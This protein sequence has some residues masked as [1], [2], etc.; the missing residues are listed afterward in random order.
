MSVALGLCLL[1]LCVLFS[2]AY[3]GAE[4]G[5]YS[6]SR[7]QVDIEAR[8]GRP[9]ARLVAWLHA[10]D[11]SLLITILIGNNLAI[12]IATHV[13]GDLA[14]HWGVSEVAL[15]VVVTVVLTPVLFIFG[16]ALPKDMF[17]RRPHALVRI[18]AP[19][20]LLSRIVFWPLERLLS[21]VSLA[22]ERTLRLEPRATRSL[23][24]RERVLH[25]FAEGRRSGALPSRAEALALNALALRTL[26]VMRAMQPWSVVE[27]LDQ[28][29]PQA[30]LYGK[31][32]DSR[33]SRLPVV[34]GEG[35]VVGYVHQLDVLTAGPEAPVLEHLRSLP[36]LAEDVAV[37]RALL[38]LRG[39]GQRAAIV[40]RDGVPVGLVTLKDLVEEISGDLAHW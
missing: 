39:S 30:D 27:C 22:L 1:L 10:R 36:T 25:F 38:T 31:V 13:S 16:E 19:F 28:A 11:A 6:L 34:D 4:I 24:G 17:R 26:P 23:R 20:I 9:L 5:F 29:L 21:L 15:G 14:E 33:F 8:Q 32:R 35:R 3:S 12:E 18:V 2:G 37:D 40:A 7:A